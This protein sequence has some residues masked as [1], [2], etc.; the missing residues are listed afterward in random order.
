RARVP[1][2]VATLQR[3]TRAAR[4]VASDDRAVAVPVLVLHDR[5]RLAVRAAER[6]G[7]V[8]VPALDPVPAEV[9]ALARARATDLLV[10]VLT[11]VADPEVSGLPVEAVAPRVAQSVGPDLVEAG[12]AHERVIRGHLVPLGPAA[13]RIERVD[14]Q[15]LAQAAV[16]V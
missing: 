16:L 6:A 9:L 10:A 3:R 12:L 4:H 14:A 5:E 11:D 7:R 2:Q 15:D 8:E 1:E 13:V